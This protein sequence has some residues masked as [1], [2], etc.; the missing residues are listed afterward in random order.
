MQKEGKNGRFP[1]IYIQTKILLI[2]KLQNEYFDKTRKKIWE[3][4][5][6]YAKFQIILT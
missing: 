2:K 6:Q 4:I 3:W 1:K 5:Y